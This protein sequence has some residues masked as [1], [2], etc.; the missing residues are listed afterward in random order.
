MKKLSLLC[1][2]RIGH[3]VASNSLELI[4]VCGGFRIGSDVSQIP[5]Q[6]RDCYKYQLSKNKWYPLPK[7]AIGVSYATMVI[8]QNR[9]VVIGGFREVANSK[10]VKVNKIQVRKYYFAKRSILFNKKVLFFC[11]VDFEL[12]Q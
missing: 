8:V 1:S 4:I 11:I 6:N 10:N 3:S 2:S 7:L 12:V 9:V 5:N